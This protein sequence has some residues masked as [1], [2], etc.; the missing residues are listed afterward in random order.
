MATPFHR[1]FVAHERVESRAKHR[2]T[3]ALAHLCRGMIKIAE[4]E[5]SG[6]DRS[7]PTKTRPG[8]SDA[9]NLPGWLPSYGPP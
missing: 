4:H 7:I 6:R 8:V 5:T 1:L 9:T 3:H 2:A